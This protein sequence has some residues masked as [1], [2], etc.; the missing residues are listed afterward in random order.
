[1][2][3]S[4]SADVVQWQNATFPRLTRGFDSRH[5]LASAPRKGR[6]LV[7]RATCEASSTGTSRAGSSRELVGTG[8]RERTHCAPFRTRLLGAAVAR[9]LGMEKVNGSIPLGG[10]MVL[11]SEP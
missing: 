9:F 8:A 2:I 7:P 1:M 10:S 4:H 11:M 6:N 3:A 5:R